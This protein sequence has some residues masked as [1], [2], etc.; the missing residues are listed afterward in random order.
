VEAGAAL[1]AEDFLFLL[2]DDFFFMK[3]ASDWLA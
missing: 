1:L 2:L 3:A